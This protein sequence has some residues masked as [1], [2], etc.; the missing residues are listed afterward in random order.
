MAKQKAEKASSGSLKK[1]AL[2]TLLFVAIAALTIWAV[3]SQNKSFSAKSFFAFLGEL[4]PL[5]LC[6]AVLAMLLYIYF[7]GAAIGVILRAVGY[8]R[9]A[10]KNTSYSA[11]DI[12]FSAITP[13]A[14]GGQPA[15]AFFMVK[16]GIPLSVTTVVLL[17]NLILYAF[18]IVFLGVIC[19][20]L[21][22]SAFY[23]FSVP[24][25]VLIIVGVVAQ[26][27]LV[28][29]FVLLLRFPT[30]LRRTGEFILE[31]LG[32]LRLCRNVQGKKEKLGASIASYGACVSLIGKKWGAIFG[33]FALNVL[34]RAC[35]IAATVFTCCAV[36]G[37][38]SHFAELWSGESMVVLASNY[39]PIPGAMGITDS[40]LLD[41]L[42]NLFD[43]ATA[44]N[45]ALFSRTV[46]F[47]LCILLC[48]G[49]T[50][51]RSVALSVRGRK[52][53]P[54]DNEKDPSDETKTL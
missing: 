23:F 22:P 20:I 18:A 10:P 40:L 48:G 39:V 16:D 30:I 38:A 3:T 14:T 5:W 53:K 7:E 28:A 2:W 43:T 33:A 21:K 15:S 46:S 34:Q 32:R 49:I 44:T 9:S 54:E 36:Q 42:G 47:Y 27:A 17:F 45:L 6:A 41:V 50:L 13:S 29:L 11:A 24:G 25:R 12:Y 37:G 1:R 52:D 35:F 26:L 31:L 8:P 51:F 4:H 19:F